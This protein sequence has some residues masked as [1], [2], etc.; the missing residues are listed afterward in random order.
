MAINYDLVRPIFGID[1]E[2][3]RTNLTKR[4]LKKIREDL[5]DRERLKDEYSRFLLFRA[6]SLY[7]HRHRC[8]AQNKFPLRWCNQVE[9][10]ASQFFLGGFTLILFSLTPTRQKGNGNYPSC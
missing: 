9:P 5:L 2:D 3:Y 10:K 4:Y 8:V 1:A 6:D 7:S